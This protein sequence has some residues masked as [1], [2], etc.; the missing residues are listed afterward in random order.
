[1]VK[2]STRLGDLHVGG[3]GGLDAS[4][5]THLGRSISRYAPARTGANRE[6]DSM[7]WMPR[8]LDLTDLLLLAA[9]GREIIGN[10]SSGGSGAAG[11]LLVGWGLSVA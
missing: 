7:H 2:N 4:A 1:M 10:F 5:L 3:P 9:A 11:L 6:Q 8:G